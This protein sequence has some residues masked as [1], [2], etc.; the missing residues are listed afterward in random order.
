MTIALP[1]N[2]QTIFVFNLPYAIPI[3]DGTY[4]VSL[5]NRVGMLSVERVQKEVVSGFTAV[6]GNIQLMF[7]KYGWS[8]F[9]KIRLTLPWPVDLQEEGRTPVLLRNAG[10]RSK[11]KETVLQ[12]LNRFI[13]TVKYVSEEYWVEPARY[14]D[15]ISYD[16]YYWDGKKEYPALKSL[17]DTGVG[18]MGVGVGNP[19]KIDEGKIKQLGDILVAEEDLD[20]GKLFI[21]SS[22]DACLQE[23]F[24]L[25]TIESVTALEIVLYEFIRKQGKKLKI[26]KRDLDNFIKEVGLTGNISIVLKMLTKGLEQIDEE[27]IATCKGAIKTRNKI[28]H[29]GLRDVYST[30]AEKRVI[31]I[32][33]MLE[34]LHKLIAMIK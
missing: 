14:Q 25:A 21:L 17:L 28:L 11:A 7:D 8:S 32:E 22:K 33:K 31:A 16:V 23:D 3:Q 24:R 27:V 4:K 9:S 29:E 18:G 30:D 34:Y 6:K 2:T 20:T 12:F 10:T 19:F 26:P 15:V 13:E 5:R 1:S